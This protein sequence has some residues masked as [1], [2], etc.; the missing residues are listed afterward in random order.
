MDNNLITRLFARINDII[1]Y[2]LSLQTQIRSATVH[3][4]NNDDTVNIVI[5]PGNTVYHNIQ[6]QSI[7]RNLRPGDNIKI[8]VENGSLSNMWIIGGFNLKYEDKQKE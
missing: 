6:N 2:K 3:S 1:D 8:I 7:Y 5:P 4:V